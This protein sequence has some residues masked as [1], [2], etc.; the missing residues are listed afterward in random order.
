[1]D[2]VIEIATDADD[3]RARCDRGVELAAR[4][5][6]VRQSP[7]AVLVAL[8]RGSLV[9]RC[10]CWWR[11]TPALDGHPVGMIGH[12]AAADRAAAGAVLERACALLAAR[13]RHQAVGPIDGSTW[14]QYRF[15]GD[16]H[17]AAPFFLEPTNPRDWP[18]D[19][20]AA[21]FSPLA[22]YASAMTNGLTADDVRTTE[23]ADVLR[24][25]GVIVRPFDMSRAEAELHAIFQLLVASF[26]RNFLYAP[27]A[28]EEFLHD[29]RAL[30]PFVQPDLTLLAERDGR[31]VGFLMAL[32]DVLQAKRGHLVD[33]V[34]VKTVA[35]APT[36]SGCGAGGALVALAHERARHLGFRRAIHALMHDGNVSGRISRRS[37]DVFRRYVL[38][39]RST[40]A[41][42]CRGG[43]R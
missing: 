14:R 10:S 38:L 22:T 18:D 15:S 20:A 31:L 39:A 12:Y 4:E 19:W 41:A 26:N 2:E 35:V 13:Q 33:T 9:A 23:A 43:V 7:D 28:E 17:R 8:R 40:N 3:I 1:M 11:R 30:L 29:S 21:G 32:P 37:A 24:K 27:I 16:G 5:Q 36:L 25:A 42:A 34:I 6:R